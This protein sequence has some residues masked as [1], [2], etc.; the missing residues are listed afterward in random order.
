MEKKRKIFQNKICRK[1]SE[2]QFLFQ[3][4]FDIADIN[5]NMT[6]KQIFRWF[7]PP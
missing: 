4:F 5:I 2:D 3:T 7:Q 1:I 6:E